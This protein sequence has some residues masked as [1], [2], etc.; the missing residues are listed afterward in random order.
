MDSFGD[1]SI[2]VSIEDHVV[3]LT[4]TVPDP[5]RR[6]ELLG[7][8]AGSPGVRHVTDRLVVREPLPMDIGASTAPPTGGTGAGDASPDDPETTVLEADVAGRS[9]GPSIEEGRR[10][11]PAVVPGDVTARTGTGPASD[12]SLGNAV[13]ELDEGERPGARTA[14]ARTG[15]PDDQPP[16]SDPPPMPDDGP[17]DAAAT[18]ESDDAEPVLPSL[19]FD[20]AD[21]VLVVDGEL[22]P[23]DDP[24]ALVESAMDSFELDFVSNAIET[25]DGV[26]EAGWLGPLVSL[27]PVLARLEAPGIEVNGRRV[28]LRGEAADSVMRDEVVEATLERLGDYAVIERIVVRER[29][30]AT[31]DAVAETGPEAGSVTEAEA[32]AAAAV[33]A[34]ADA[35]VRAAMEANADARVDAGTSTDG[36]ADADGT[37]GADKTADADGTADVARDSSASG[38]DSG[39]PPGGGAREETATALP[40]ETS[41]ETDADAPS[42]GDGAPGSR[43][44]RADLD[45]LPNLRILFRSGSDRLTAESFSVLD[46]VSEVLQRHPGVPITIGGH[47]DAAGGTSANLQLSQ[48]RANAVREHLVARGVERE[49]IT[50][51]GYGESLP[52]ADN[53]TAE[54]RAINRRIE[55]T[56]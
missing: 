40:S 44:L 55:F 19:R 33:E 16:E 46:A 30:A 29:A 43:A 50:A 12:V 6:D 8:A 27:L 2:A 31:D 37:A 23:V 39:N 53:A 35:A 7:A 51:R 1:A 17:A 48:L 20:I 32:R 38:D 41:A 49:R 45:A 56:Y 26:A 21:G 54:G 25:R 28:T 42:E 14:E 34:A 22:S 47:T 3:T 24:A 4:G 10:A 15:A 52:I 9:E 5:E 13:A 18:D 36:T 11:V